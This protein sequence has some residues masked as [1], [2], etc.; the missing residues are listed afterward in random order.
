MSSLSLA[1]AS[2]S[3]VSVVRTATHQTFGERGRQ[4]V[5]VAGLQLRAQDRCLSAT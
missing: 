4:V 1:A 2:F 5:F 3:V